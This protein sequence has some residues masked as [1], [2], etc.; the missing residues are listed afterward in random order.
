M[1]ASLNC[2]RGLHTSTNPPRGVRAGWK[3]VSCPTAVIRGSID[4]HAMQNDRELACDCNL[5]LAEPVALGE[6]NP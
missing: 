2:G 3:S 4:P 1:A 5:G 6:P